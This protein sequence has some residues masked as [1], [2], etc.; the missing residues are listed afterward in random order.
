M[1]N[2]PDTPINFFKVKAH[3]HLIGDGS[4]DALAKHAAL[5]NYGHDKAFPS[6]S[7]DGNPYAHIYWLA[8]E[9]NETTQTTTRISLAPLQNIKDKLKAHMSKHHSLG[10]ANTNSDYYKYWK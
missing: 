6:P 8:E 10:D 2:V 7:P 5:H 3:F 4:A 9:N 1:I